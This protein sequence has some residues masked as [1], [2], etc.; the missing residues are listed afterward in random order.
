MTKGLH[1]FSVSNF[2]FHSL[3]LV[4]IAFEEG[5]SNPKLEAGGKKSIFNFCPNLRTNKR[6]V[7]INASFSSRN[8]PL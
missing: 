8:A 1:K 7:R 2:S 3:R 4:F 5:E 6:L